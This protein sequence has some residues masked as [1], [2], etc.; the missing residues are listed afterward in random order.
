M[1]RC[2]EECFVKKELPKSLKEKRMFMLMKLLKQ[3]RR[4][5]RLLRKKHLNLWM[6]YR[7]RTIMLRA[8][9][10]WRL[11]AN[12]LRCVNNT[13]SL[14]KQFR[15]NKAVEEIDGVVLKELQVHRALLDQWVEVEK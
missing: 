15:K 7:I 9:H 3:Q 13:A 10:T 14:L 5:I 11:R 4:A 2:L 12:T 8:F 1:M 6:Q